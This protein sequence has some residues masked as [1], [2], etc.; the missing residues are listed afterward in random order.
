MHGQTTRELAEYQ[1]GERYPGMAAERR[2][3]EVADLRAKLGGG[4]EAIAKL[5][6]HVGHSEDD[7]DEDGKSPATDAL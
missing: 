5:T 4:A 2:A 3:K 1:S 6:G 7:V